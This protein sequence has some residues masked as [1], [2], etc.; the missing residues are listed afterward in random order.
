MN[1]DRSSLQFITKSGSMESDTKKQA[2]L[3]KPTP[4]LRCDKVCDPSLLPKKGPIPKYCS[5]ECKRLHNTVTKTCKACGK[6]FSFF[7]AS[8]VEENTRPRRFC[9]IS[10][11]MKGQHADP[12]S[13]EKW[14]MAMRPHWDKG[15]PIKGKKNPGSSAYMKARQ[16][17]YPQK[18]LAERTGLVTE[19]PI[20]TRPIRHLFQGIAN[21]FKADL[22]DPARMLDIEVDGYDHTT[23]RGKEA[24]ARRD[25]ALSLL[26]W[27]VL[28]FSNQMVMENTDSVVEAIRSFTTSKSPTTTTTLPMAS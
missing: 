1:T 2:S 24:D 18:L 8:I 17:P 15:P 11:K 5:I 10:C 4:C 14:R 6:E 3:R 28:R 25:K 12:E 13:H 23:S 19:Y 21:H 27:S 22:A 20:K 9:N 26:G 16:M 7:R